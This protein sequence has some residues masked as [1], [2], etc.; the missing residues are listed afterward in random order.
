M[1]IDGLLTAFYQ[2]AA[3]EAARY[4]LT[5]TEF[6]LLRVCLRR[7]EECTA[8]E[9]ARILPVDTSRISRM[10][11]VLVD[12]GLLRRRR[13]PSDRRVVML[14]LTEEGVEMTSQILEVINQ[15]NTRLMEG[16]DEDEI[17]VFSSVV[18]RIVANHTAMQ[19]SE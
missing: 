2:R 6:N 1:S 16:I 5:A 3:K 9:L 10:V 19:N 7:Q 17:R 4:N 13:L 15:N 14:S 18:S 8:T 12:R 11:T